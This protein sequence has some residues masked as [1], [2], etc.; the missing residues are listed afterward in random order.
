MDQQHEWA[1]NS[2]DKSNSTGKLH[3]RKDESIGR[4]QNNRISGVPSFEMSKHMLLR[5][6]K[7]SFKEITDEMIL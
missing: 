6:E 2:L 7:V 5:L 4:K 1:L 3:T